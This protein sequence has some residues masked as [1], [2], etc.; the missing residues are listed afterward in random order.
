[1]D[2]VLRE[3]LRVENFRSRNLLR[4][5]SI[6]GRSRLESVEIVIYNS[7]LGVFTKDLSR[8][9]GQWRSHIYA[10]WVTWS[11]E[12]KKN[13]LIMYF[14][15]ILHHL[16]KLQ[17]PTLWPDPHATS[18][19]RPHSLL[20]CPML[21]PSPLRSRRRPTGRRCRPS[22]SAALRGLQA[23]LSASRSLSVRHLQFCPLRLL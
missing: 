5:K 11:T 16:I 12:I 9:C 8:L 22:P 6:A 2:F 19:F 1:M 10:R 17:R 4:H 18:H 7:V 20:V 13:P 15:K 3:R 21:S 14:L 23:L